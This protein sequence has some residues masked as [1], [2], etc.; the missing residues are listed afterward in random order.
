[1]NLIIGSL[2]YI[3]HV[4]RDF[5]LEHA[6]DYDKSDEEIETEL[7]KALTNLYKK[8]GETKTYFPDKRDDDYNS[9]SIDAFEEFQKSIF[10]LEI[11]NLYGLKP[12]YREIVLEIANMMEE[13]ME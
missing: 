13:Y 9:E 8:E 1:M 3:Q 7:N 10:C 11:N 6:E 5:L 12:E 2:S 4:P